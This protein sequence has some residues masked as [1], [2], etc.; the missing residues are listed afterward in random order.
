MG[1]MRDDLQLADVVVERKGSQFRLGPISHSFRR[2]ITAVVGV[3]GAGKSTLFSAIAGTEKIADGVVQLPESHTSVRRRIGFLPQ[4]PTFPPSAT[5]EDVLTLLAW[6]V[7]VARP[8][9]EVTRVS[10]RLDLN[11]LRRKRVKHLS[12]GMIRRLGI[13][14]AMIGSPEV[15][16]LDEPTAGLDPIQRISVRDAITESCGDTVTLVSTHLVEDV[17]NLADSVVVLND[18]APVFA[19]S[20]RELESLAPLSSTRGESRL[21]S[22]LTHLYLGGS[23]D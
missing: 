11:G 3:N 22:A 23:D 21:E 10:A 20:V 1:G 8:P 12:G 4:T 9:D 16:L 2:G 13:A 19:G 6:A 7:G 17:R 14:Q 5:V 15:L 18:G